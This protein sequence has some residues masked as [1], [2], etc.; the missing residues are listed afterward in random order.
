M[1]I[2]AETNVK[3]K[4]FRLLRGCRGMVRTQAGPSEKPYDLE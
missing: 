3:E 4:A 1:V 2:P